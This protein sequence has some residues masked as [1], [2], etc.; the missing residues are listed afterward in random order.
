MKQ[1]FNWLLPQLC[2]WCLQP[3]HAHD[4]QLCSY[5]IAALPRLSPRQD[6]LGRS[7]ISASLAAVHFDGLLSLSWY[8]LPWSHWIVQWKFQRDL[9]VADALLLLFR[10]QCE[11]WRDAG[12]TADAICYIPMTRWRRWLRGFNQAQQ[13]AAV[14]A[15]AFQLP[16]WHGLRCRKQWH[17]VG[18]NASSR[19]A[20]H[21]RFC[22][23]DL[24]VPSCVLLIDDV[25]TTGSTCNQIA[26]LLKDAG[27]TSIIVIT[28]AITAPPSGI[29]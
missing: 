19:R 15:E 25:I 23:G 24:D 14:A 6:Q 21:D 1:Q 12:I 20:A 27:C 11:L 9:A 8:Q 29:S 28:L 10:Q 2:L 18:H 4:T 7:G 26:A 13:L 16:L 5:C 22:L 3:M 17:Q